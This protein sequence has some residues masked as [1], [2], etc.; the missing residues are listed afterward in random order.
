MGKFKVGDR[1]QTDGGYGFD[2]NEGTVVGEINTLV[3]VRLDEIPSGENKAT[4]SYYPSEL[5]PVATASVATAT[6]RFKV[7][8]RVRTD[9]GYTFDPNEGVI[10]AVNVG[11]DDDIYTVSKID[12]PHTNLDEEWNYRTDDLSPVAVAASN[13]NLE[14]RLTIREGRYYLTRGGRKVGPATPSGDTDYPWRIGDLTYTDSGAWVDG[15]ED[16]NDLVAEADEPANDNGSTAG[17]TV[18]LCAYDD[19]PGWYVTELGRA[20]ADGYAA[21]LRASQEQAA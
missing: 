8:D 20:Y 11:G 6:G 17:F 9:G 3:I 13:S 14:Q 7:G 21:G 12:H 10:T 1:V 18:P 2:P 4:W 15:M 5:L 16:G 19:E